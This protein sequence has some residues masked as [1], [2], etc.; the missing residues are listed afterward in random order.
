MD[1]LQ[2]IMAK[3]GVAS[4]RKCEQ[5]IL[6]GRVRVN[7]R[8]VDHLGAKADSS[9]DQIEVDGKVLKLSE[10]FVY[11]LLNKPAGFITSVTDP[12][13]R[14]TVLDLVREKNVRI[15]P[16]GRLDVNTEGLL[17]LTNDGE[18]AFRLTHPRYKV[19][20]TYFVEVV[21]TP[22]AQ[23]LAQLEKGVNLDDGPTAPAKLKV[24]ALGERASKLEI[25]I[26]EGRKRQVRRMFA[27]IGHNVVYLKRTAFGSLDVSGIDIGDY[28]YLNEGEV[29]SLRA[30]V[31]LDE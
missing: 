16:V 31:G 27:L 10:Q 29:D 4:R 11:V 2:K 18:L 5:L 26:R 8:V 6:D 20:K 25:T 1:R 28:R 13:A 22:S 7:G 15:Y 17:L 14:R 3:A 9:T 24:I 21:G 23:A 12:R 19:E 30:L